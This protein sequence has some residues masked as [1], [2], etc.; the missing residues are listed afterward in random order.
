M[1]INLGLSFWTMILAVLT[2]FILLTLKLTGTITLTWFWVF[3]P[4]ILGIGLVTSFVILWLLFMFIIALIQ[5][6]LRK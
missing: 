1:K 6:F 5:A 4:I 2:T 3:F